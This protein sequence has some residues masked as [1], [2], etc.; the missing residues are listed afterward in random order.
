MPRTFLVLVSL[1]GGLSV[2]ACSSPSSSGGTQPTCGTGGND[3]GVCLGT[4]VTCATN[5][6]T[7][8]VSF[9][10]DILPILQPGCAI[11]GSTCHGAPSVVSQQRPYLGS[12]DGGTDAA[13]GP[14]RASSASR[15]TRTRRCPSSR[16]AIL[17]TAT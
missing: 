5:L 2:T 4:Y 11:A 17:P 15:R 8:N 3:G 7:P 9:K 12:F 16:P 10:D 13:G 1:L 14:A 6:T